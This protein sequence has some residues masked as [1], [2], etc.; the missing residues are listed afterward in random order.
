LAAT[1]AAAVMLAACARPEQAL[2]DRF[3][4][5]SRLR[6]TTALQAVS[7]VTFEP[8]QQ[9]IVR[10]FHVTSVTPERVEG[11]TVTKDV[12]VE[13]PVILPDGQT[14]Q[15]T[16]V[17]TLQRAPGASTWIVTGFRDAAASRPAPRS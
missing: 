10:A 11:Q 6:D 5:A 2:L 17:L 16:L 13:A 7:T 14:V 15:K 1:T 12:T 8:L 9:G 3:F 4:G